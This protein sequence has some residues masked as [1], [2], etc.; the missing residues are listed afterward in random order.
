LVKG[1]EKMTE[2]EKKTDDTGRTAEA[3]RREFLTKAVAAAGALAASGVLASALN[4][5]AEAQTV[6][7]AP[8]RRTEV[9]RTEV[10]KDTPLKYAK[11]ANGH[12]MTLGGQQL[13][14]ILVREGLLNKDL[15]GKSSV[16]TLKLEWS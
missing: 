12:E 1:S 2:D 11:L 9:Q 3:E 7:M 16:M 10:V 5:E 4:T 6:K 8:A 14:D 13:N 15:T